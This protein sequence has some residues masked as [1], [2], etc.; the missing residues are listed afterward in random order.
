M[1]IAGGR[2]ELAA[3]ECDS[4]HLDQAAQALDRMETLIDDLLQL[5]R[6]GDLEPEWIDLSAFAQTC[7][8]N[9]ETDESEIKIEVD[10][11]IYADRSR[12]HQLFENLMR[13]AVEHVGSDVT[14]T[15]GGLLD[16]FYIE[17][18]GPGIPADEREQIFDPGYSTSDDGTGFGLDIVKQVV[19]EHEWEIGV[20]DG[21]TG[22]ARFA[23]TDVETK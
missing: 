18:N 16:G 13:N 19:T 9:V 7:W 15:V 11:E 3:E 10:Q 8:Q 12:V 1:N 20:T 14:I 2:V 4:G 6:T 5:A 23:I 22:G 17:D 21:S